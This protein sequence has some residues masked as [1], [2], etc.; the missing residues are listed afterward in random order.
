MDEKKIIKKSSGPTALG[1][2]KIIFSC[3]PHG[4]K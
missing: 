4:P 3:S 2:A 1:S